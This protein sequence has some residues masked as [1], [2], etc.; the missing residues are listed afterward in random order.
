MLLGTDRGAEYMNASV[1]AALITGAATF[2]GA[3]IAAIGA[4]RVAE[5]NRAAATNAPPP[6][7]WLGIS[8]AGWR[9]AAITL[10][11]VA[12]AAFAM[13]IYFLL[14]DSKGKQTDA[15]GA[16]K[17]D[18]KSAQP[19]AGATPSKSSTVPTPTDTDPGSSPPPSPAPSASATGSQLFG[20]G[21]GVI[22]F[23]LM[24]VDLDVN[25]AQQTTLSNGKATD[26]QTDDPSGSGIN[27]RLVRS[28][29]SL[30]TSLI[31][32]VPPG[33]TVADAAG[34]LRLLTQEG[35][36]AGHE[37]P[38]VRGDSVCLT[39]DND[40][41]HVAV[42][43]IGAIHIDQSTKTRNAAKYTATI[44]TYPDGS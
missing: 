42:V 10:G 44:W 32:K 16:P 34:C 29:L 28:N 5:L 19:S 9:R 30:S 40:P 15:A 14:P 20:H 4:I 23:N 31:A 24:G 37:V 21:D 18:H 11:I 43:K 1:G 8:A 26:I 7:N 17:Q 2:A 25:P 38:V 6:T 12:L 13:G 39:T 3:V 33:Q 41:Q 22:G 36:P 27:L 35:E